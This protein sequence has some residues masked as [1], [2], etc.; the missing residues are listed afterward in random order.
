MG[1]PASVTGKRYCIRRTGARS[2]IRF[3]RHPGEG[4]V[5]DAVAR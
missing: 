3:L 5:A 2:R 4:R 1:T